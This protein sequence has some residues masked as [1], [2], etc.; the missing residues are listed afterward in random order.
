[1]EQLGGSFRDRLKNEVMRVSVDLVIMRSS[2]AVSRPVYI[3]VLAGF[4]C[5]Y[6]CIGVC[7]YV[8]R[9]VSV[10]GKRAHPC[11]CTGLCFV[12]LMCLLCGCVR[13]K[14][15]VGVWRYV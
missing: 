15:F 3:L 13:S 11:V 12:C 10:Y 4:V 8:G 14:L 7:V 5:V 6:G 1:M 2:S 9:C